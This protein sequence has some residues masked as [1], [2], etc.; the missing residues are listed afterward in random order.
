MYVLFY[1]SFY[2]EIKIYAQVN[3]YIQD[4]YCISKDRIS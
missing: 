3:R 4:E 2:A 1:S